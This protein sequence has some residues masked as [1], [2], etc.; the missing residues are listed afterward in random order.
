MQCFFSRRSRLFRLDAITAPSLAGHF[1]TEIKLNDDAPFEVR[2][3]VDCWRARW[4]WSDGKRWLLLAPG[5]GR[6]LW[7]RGLVV[8]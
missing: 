2:A 3:R 6:L 1:D 4:R 5:R 7:G 8:V